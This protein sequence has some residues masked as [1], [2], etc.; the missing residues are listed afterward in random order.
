MKRLE[1]CALPP[2]TG[3]TRPDY[4]Q[5]ERVTLDSPAL[6]VMT[7]LKRV[8]VVTT[9]P[10][11]SLNNVHEHMIHNG[12]R[13]VLVTDAQQHVIGLLTATDLLGPRPL[14]V[15]RENS[16]P[17]DQLRVEHIMTP[18]RK[19]QALKYSDVTH[20]DVG[21][22]VNTL[23]DAERQHALVIDSDGDGERVRG[24]FSISQIERQLGT[25][26]EPTHASHNLAELEHELSG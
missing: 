26:L 12:V 10:Q 16:I 9:S 7:D 14:L 23:R 17:H 18:A 19:V 20:A 11:V 8:K 6:K 5:V 13:M 21:E 15:S 24:I 1:F 25:H 4:E 2:A 22:I 3:I